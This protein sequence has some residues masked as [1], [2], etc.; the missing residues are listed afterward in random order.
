MGFPACISEGCEVSR[1]K[2]PGKRG[3]GARWVFHASGYLAQ[4]RGT[5]RVSTGLSGARS[6]KE[7]KDGTGR[8]RSVCWTLSF[9]E[10]LFH[11][12]DRQGWSCAVCGFTPQVPAPTRAE[13]AC[14]LEPG[15][16]QVPAWGGQE[17]GHALW[18]SHGAR[19][20]KLAPRH[21]M[22]TVLMAVGGL[23][24]GVLLLGEKF[25]EQSPTLGWA[26]IRGPGLS[27]YQPCIPR[28]GVEDG[29]MAGTL[30]ASGTAWPIQHRQLRVV[31]AGQATGQLCLCAHSGTVWARCQ[32]IALGVPG[33]L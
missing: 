23:P 8:C 4:L 30:A 29:P 31:V 5:S 20:R 16:S 19:V 17:P 10:F 18:P 6:H 28:K 7:A 24:T 11:L 32:L 25:P 3:Q 13:P 26:L 21:P 22:P 14:S 2:T 15:T 1:Q 9:A 33:A 27:L 12:S